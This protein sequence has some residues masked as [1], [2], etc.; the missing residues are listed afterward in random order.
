MVKEA[1]GGGVSQPLHVADLADAVK[2]VL[3]DTSHPVLNVCGSRELGADLLCTLICEQQHV[4]PS[5]VTWENPACITI[6]SSEL[7]RDELGWKDFHDLA[8][9]L[10][11]GEIVFERP[12]GKTQGE[13]KSIVPKALR[14]LIEN[15]LIFAAFFAI[16]YFSGQ[17][18]L[19]SQVN[20]MMIYVILISVSYNIYQSALAAI[21]ASAAYLFGQ[22]LAVFDFNSFDTAAG[23]VLTIM[24]FV[25]LG[26][27]VSYTTSMLK[28]RNRSLRLDLEILKDE[29]A[30]LK[31]IN[32][33][34]VLIKNEYESRLLTSR[35]GF[36]KLYKMISRLMVQEPDR[37]L[38]ETMQVIAELVRTNTV[39]VYQGQ[40][41]SPWLRL[42][43]SL[44][45]EST[46]G[47][48]TWNISEYPRI[49]DAVMRG[50]LYQGE[51]GSDEPA[52]V[53][54][55]ICKDVTEAVVV[56]RTMPYESESLYHIN[57]LKTM[58][59]LLRDSMEKALQYEEMSREEHY[60]EKTDI[61][62]PEAFRRRISLAQEKAEKGIAEY[63]L[64]EFPYSGSIT[65]AAETAGELL[66]VTDCLGTD[67]EGRLFA[68]L[69]N[70][71]PDNLENL[72]RRLIESDMAIRSVSTDQDAL[73]D[74]ARHG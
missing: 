24:E 4:K 51:L 29:Y 8:R 41:G 13:K 55:V 43:G 68:L 59:L 40:A 73:R 48:K 45:E 6:A 26:L 42:V 14:Q 10:A 34:N 65:V 15:L 39:A 54:P 74:E 7:I 53:L 57:L 62:K 72:Q 32:E 64:V 47:G 1:W 23:S 44:N 36:P 27:L 30:D 52:I 18:A 70:T 38:M 58:S 50:E 66:R 12:S 60:Y 71:S 21:L 61:L 16:D 19:L 25:F 3:E 37:I 20:W 22:Q 11:D 69:N 56:I 63:C 9:Q 67:G 17:N 31:A 46:M 33:E 5:S 2:R 28:E 49:Y 35:T